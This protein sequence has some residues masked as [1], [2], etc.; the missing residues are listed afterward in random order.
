MHAL[1]LPL[2]EVVTTGKVAEAIQL[3]ERIIDLLIAE[4]FGYAYSTNIILQEVMLLFAREHS[5]ALPARH[6]E[7]NK[8]MIYIH[9]NLDKVIRVDELITQSGMSRD[10]FLSPVSAQ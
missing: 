9:R 3:C 4:P 5:A 8:I 6:T 2:N 7:L 1:Q 10:Y